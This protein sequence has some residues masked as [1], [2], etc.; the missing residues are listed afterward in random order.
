M[1]PSSSVRPLSRPPRPAL[2]LAPTRSDHTPFF[3]RAGLYAPSP[4]RPTRLEHHPTTTSDR[5]A[6]S[7]RTITSNRTITA[8]RPALPPT[9]ASRGGDTGAASSTAAVA[10]ASEVPLH[11]HGAHIETATKAPHSH[12][13]LGRMFGNI[14]RRSSVSA[15]YVKSKSSGESIDS[16]TISARRFAARAT[17]NTTAPS[18]PALADSPSYHALRSHQETPHSPSPLQHPTRPVRALSH[19]SRLISAPTLAPIPGSSTSTPAPAPFAGPDDDGGNESPAELVISM[20][21]QAQ[22]SPSPSASASA[23]GGSTPTTRSEPSVEQQEQQQ[24]QRDDAA[25]Q[26]HRP[27]HTRR[28]QLAS[29]PAGLKSYP[30]AVTSPSGRTRLVSSRPLSLTASLTDSDYS[31]QQGLASRFSDPSPSPHPASSSGAPSVASGR[32]GRSGRSARSGRSTRSAKSGGD[33]APVRPLRPGE[34]HKAREGRSSQVGAKSHFSDWTPTP[35]ASSEGARSVRPPPA[36]SSTDG[37][38]GGGAA[39]DEAGPAGAQLP[40]VTEGVAISSRLTP[41]PPPPP[42]PGVVAPAAID[43]AQPGVAR[44]GTTAEQVSEQMAQRSRTAQGRAAHIFEAASAAPHLV[45]APARFKRGRARAVSV[46]LT[47]SPVRGGGGGGGDD[48]DPS[49]A[50]TVPPPARSLAN[51]QP[52]L[53]STEPTS[54]HAESLSAAASTPPRSRPT[55]HRHVRIAT[56]Q[57]SSTTLRP[58]PPPPSSLEGIVSLPR[59]P[60]PPRRSPTAPPLALALALDHPSPSPAPTPLSLAARLPAPAAARLMA[61]RSLSAPAR[62]SHVL[63]AARAA[64]ELV[65]APARLVRRPVRGGAARPPR[66]AASLEPGAGPHGAEEAP[67]GL[68]STPPPPAL[69]LSARPLESSTPSGIGAGAAGA[70]GAA[71]PPAPCSTAADA[72]G[73]GAFPRSPVVEGAAPPASPAG[74]STDLAWALPGLACARALAAAAT[75]DSMLRRSRTARERA[76]HCAAAARGAPGMVLWRGQ[77]W[78]AVGVGVGV[79]AGRGAGAGGGAGEGGR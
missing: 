25:E 76:A 69:K 18:S 23:G 24:Q 28:V 11:G 62:T 68:M 30:R 6:T 29:V 52:D 73:T 71:R 74:D 17:P 3:A 36:R 67:A 41:S 61:L 19:P 44:S 50:H 1:R 42:A 5:T 46:S 13:H 77:D 20:P 63:E 35:P 10:S 47:S 56:P 38:S 66:S 22:A 64:P 12:W 21:A 54:R 79:A 40:T 33:E 75:A 32:S 70:A 48:G 26:P 65:Y 31:W 34:Q 37:S 4:L 53:S 7:D 55:Q 2:L 15:P 45:Y 72:L 16:S 57:L 9:S 8:R 60:C 78:R 39:L 43:Y 27:Q 58:P 59:T 14:L 51:A 49:A